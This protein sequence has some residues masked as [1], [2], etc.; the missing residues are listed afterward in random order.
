MIESQDPVGETLIADLNL[1]RAQT[2]HAQSL[3]E[4]EVIGTGLENQADATGSGALVVVL[5]LFV[6][7]PGGCLCVGDL[8]T[9]DLKKVADDLV[10]GLLHPTAIDGGRQPPKI[11]WRRGFYW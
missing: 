7:V 10:V 11:D 4:I 3:A 1:G 9:L 5:C 2:P 6:L 8:E